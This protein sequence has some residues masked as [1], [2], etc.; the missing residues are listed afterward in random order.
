VILSADL[1]AAYAAGMPLKA[2]LIVERGRFQAFVEGGAFWTG[3]D[4]VLTTFDTAASDFLLGPRGQFNLLPRPGWDGAVGFDYKFAASPWHVSGQFRL[5][6]A[7]ASDSATSAIGPVLFNLLAPFIFVV[8]A[9]GQAAATLKETHW[10]AD[11]AVG[12]DLT[13]GPDAMQVKVGVR[14]A[15]LSSKFRLTDS[16]HATFKEFPTS[17]NLFFIDDTQS[18]DST[19]NA[20]FRG[21]GPRIG[22]E[23]AAPLAAGWQFDYQ[24]G[25]AAL[26]GIRTFDSAVSSLEIVNSNLPGLPNGPHGSLFTFLQQ[27]SATVANVDM[28]VGLAYWVNPAFKLSA[29]YRLDAYFAALMDGNLNTMYRYFHGPRVAGTVSF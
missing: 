14:V 8:N 21:A 16:V 2:P 17:L 24:A 25:V 18:S 12:H 3:G 6:Q 23:G 27:K 28:Q 13:T 20:T 15:E 26:F 4:P 9:N 11:F 7:N 10:L 19:R 22:I 1:P 5:G 29:S